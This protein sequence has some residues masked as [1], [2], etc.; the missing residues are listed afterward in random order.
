MSLCPHR[1]YV[2]E[3]KPYKGLSYNIIPDDMWVYILSFLSSE[4]ISR[5]ATKNAFIFT[6][7]AENA[8]CIANSFKKKESDIIWRFMKSSTTTRQD[9]F[10]NTVQF[11][12][13]SHVYHQSKFSKEWFNDRYIAENGFTCAFF[14]DK[15]KDIVSRQLMSVL[16]Y[17][18]FKTYY[19]HRAIRLDKEKLDFMLDL[20]LNNFKPDTYTGSGYY[21]AAVK[22][23][24]IFLENVSKL[25]RYGYYPIFISSMVKH[26]RDRTIEIMFSLIEEK[27]DKDVLYE[28]AKISSIYNTKDIQTFLA[29]RKELKTYNIPDVTFMQVCKLCPKIEVFTEIIKS[30]I[31]S[32]VALFCMRSSANSKI[33]LQKYID[34]INA[35]RGQYGITNETLGIVFK[36]LCPFGAIP[37]EDLENLIKLCS[38]YTIKQ[39]GIINGYEL[40]MPHLN[41]AENMR[42]KFRNENILGITDFRS[43]PLD[44]Y[45]KLISVLSPYQQKKFQELYQKLE[46]NDIFL[47]RNFKH[48][49]ILE[50]NS[51]H[52]IFQM[53]PLCEYVNYVPTRNF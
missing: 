32:E 37:Y 11:I 40:V 23:N 34:I 29:I 20:I 6:F 48:F 17:Y 5:A 39:Q 1:P 4:E 51:K 50:K 43:I 8:E 52:I 38:I 24:P 36:Q 31:P 26:Y 15:Q 49:W 30:G 25:E 12:N 33:D 46:P 41:E 10:Y 53:T 2:I 22:M 7:I 27:V 18:N 44:I 28:L 42:I 19:S 14:R 9:I 35:L 21:Y 45:M 3:Q 16:L 47:S 13:L